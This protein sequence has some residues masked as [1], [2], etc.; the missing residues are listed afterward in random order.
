MIDCMPIS[1]TGKTEEIGAM[2]AFL[3][4]NDAGWITGQVIAV[5]GGHTLRQGPDI[6]ELLRATMPD[7]S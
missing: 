5:D 1:R 6:V 7:E 2:V 4:S 3:L